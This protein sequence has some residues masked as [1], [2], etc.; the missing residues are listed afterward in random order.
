VVETTDRCQVRV[1]RR[2]SQGLSTILLIQQ[3]M[4]SFRYAVL[5]PSVSAEAMA[6]VTERLESKAA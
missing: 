4:Q 2:V 3:R 6:F 1:L 5:S